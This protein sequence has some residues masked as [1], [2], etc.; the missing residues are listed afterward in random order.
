MSILTIINITMCPTNYRISF[1]NWR[2]H[3]A[4]S[5]ALSRAINFDSIVNRAKHVY[6]E[7][8]Q[9]ITTPPSMKTYPLVDFESF[10]D[11]IWFASQYPS[12]T[13]GYLA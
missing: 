5:V 10:I 9:D 4:S 12:S 1:E 11:D 8:F 6:L 3:S 2:S 13:V 7:D